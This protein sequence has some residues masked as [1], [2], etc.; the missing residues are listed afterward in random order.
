MNTSTK[1]TTLHLCDFDGTLTRAD[2]LLR[3][4]R[5]AVPVWRL[6]LVAIV[7]F[8]RFLALVFRGKWSN[9][10]GKETLLAQLFKHQPARELGALGERFCA[11]KLTAL[12]RHD[13]LDQLRA[14][15]QKGDI[16]AVVSASPDI[17]LRPFC[18]A[19]GFDLICTEL[20]F[21]REGPHGEMQ[22][23]GRLATPNCNGT[24]KA[25][26]I[27]AAY[28]LCFFSKII[29]YGNSRGDAAMFELAHE[30]LRF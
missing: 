26:R 11:E 8:F 7:L 25:R 14:A 15:R 16:V 19:E 24:E 9:E 23:T 5:F 28:D 12:L 4:L 2:S 22:F 13:L 3:F 6:P 21:A 27:M 18:R 29:A 17:W 20:E 1:A 10:A 30:V